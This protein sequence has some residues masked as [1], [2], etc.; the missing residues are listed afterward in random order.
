[1]THHHLFLP[2]RRHQ[3][4]AG[5]ALPKRRNKR[6]VAAA[7]NKSLPG[8]AAGLPIVILNF[9]AP[10]SVPE[11]TYTQRGLNLPEAAG[12][13]VGSEWT[14][15]AG[16]GIRTGFLRNPVLHPP[17]DPPRIIFKC[18]FS[19]CEQNHL[20]VGETVPFKPLTM[21][22]NPFCCGFFFFSSDFFDITVMSSQHWC[23]LPNPSTHR[24]FKGSHLP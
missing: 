7:E 4:R 6:C 12:K 19:V 3:P 13:W 16:W 21:M 24:E 22:P 20:E 23:L 10:P 9:I 18:C 2:F 8:S 15:F 14:V 1:M 17:H 5:W 11:G